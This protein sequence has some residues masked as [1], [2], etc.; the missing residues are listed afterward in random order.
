[1]AVKMHE[2]AELSR[3]T[4]RV[5]RWAALVDKKINKAIKFNGISYHLFCPFSTHSML[6]KPMLT[7]PHAVPIFQYQLLYPTKQVVQ[8]TKSREGRLPSRVA[9]WS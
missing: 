3:V 7:I 9:T 2:V 8:S 5:R 1:M 6:S 4:H